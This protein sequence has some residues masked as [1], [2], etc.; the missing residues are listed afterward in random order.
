MTSFSLGGAQHNI[1]P[2]NST[3]RPAHVS[4]RGEDRMHFSAGLKCCAVSRGTDAPM[5]CSREPCLLGEELVCNRLRFMSPPKIHMLNPK[6]QCVDTWR[7]G[8]WEAIRWLGEALMNGISGLIKQA[9]REHPCLFHHVRMQQEDI[10]LWIRKE[11]IQQTLKSVG[12]LI[13]DFQP[14]ELW[15]NFCWL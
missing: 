10:H 8:P 12:A 3:L 5:C 7:W 15:Q 14:P 11:A 2:A 4:P 9:F 1:F 6:G 13:L